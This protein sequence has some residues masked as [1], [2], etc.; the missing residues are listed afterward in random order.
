M[1]TYIFTE[2]ERKLIERW[3]RGEITGSNRSWTQL[4]YRVRSA[5]HLVSDINLFLELQRR[6]A[7]PETA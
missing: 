3:S 1:R 4:V 5:T 6:L 2:R 7:E